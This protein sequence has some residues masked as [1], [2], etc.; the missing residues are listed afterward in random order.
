MSQARVP[1]FGAAA[2]SA[3]RLRQFWRQPRGTPIS[4]AYVMNVK[5]AFYFCFEVRHNYDFSV[6]P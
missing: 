5:M 6:T 3:E 1:G 2:T 4:F